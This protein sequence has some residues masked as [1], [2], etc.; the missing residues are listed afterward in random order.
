MKFLKSKVETK[1]GTT[2][3]NEIFNYIDNYINNWY[4]NE[5]ELICYIKEKVIPYNNYR[6]FLNTDT[7]KDR[8]FLPAV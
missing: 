8:D 1:F 3:F 4:S 5:N 6:K 2:E 7:L